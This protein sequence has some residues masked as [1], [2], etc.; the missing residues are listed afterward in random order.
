MRAEA[1]MKINPTFFE[2]GLILFSES[3]LQQEKGFPMPLRGSWNLL[4]LL[5]AIS[6]LGC[7]SGGP[8]MAPVSGVVTYKGAP[9]EGAVVSFTSADAPRGSSGTTDAQGI[10][11]LSTFGEFDGAPL[12]SFRVSVIKLDPAAKPDS[13][14]KTTEIKADQ[15]LPGGGTPKLETTLP[16]AGAGM[17]PSP[18]GASAGPP[19]LLPAKYA[20]PGKS[21]L[22]AKVEAGKENK[23]DF[24]LT[25]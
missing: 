19:S 16:G 10:Y 5:A 12:G 15:P 6:F 4:L 17:M 23:F 3:P 22:T 11:K 9:V 20:D 13:A 1:Q 7:S 21:G 2:A 24:T 8:A 18:P 25:D 14:M